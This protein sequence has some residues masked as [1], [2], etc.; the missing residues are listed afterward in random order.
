MKRIVALLCGYV[1]FAVA[2]P[3][4]AG[5]AF[6][7]GFGQGGWDRADWELVKSPR[8]PHFGD[9]H[10]RADHIENKTP[11]E[12]TPKEL[13][14]KRAGETYT[15]M[16]LKKRF[17]GSVTISSTMAFADRMAPLLVIAP[18]LGRDAQGRAEY[19]E[20]FEI[21]IYDKGVNVWHHSYADGK[22]SWKKACY[23]TFPL[24]PNTPYTLT[25]KLTKTGRGK[26]L[27]IQVADREL[28]YLDD[29]L[30]DAFQVGITGCEG[31]NRFYNF[32]VESR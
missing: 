22:P 1:L 21:V 13:L 8:W 2:S 17:Q 6:Q 26:M 31:V 4:A 25:V 23:S 5:D 27:S 18:D 20:H 24:E 15:S 11:A 30:P 7:C 3:L 9:W 10:Q 19:R 12:A 28:G 16:V 29:S 32:S 14:G